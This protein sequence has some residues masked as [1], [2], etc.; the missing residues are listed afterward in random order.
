MTR[1]M[2]ILPMVFL[3][4]VLGVFLSAEVGW[5]GE[6]QAVAAEKTAAL[7]SNEEIPEAI[8]ALQNTGKAFV[9]IGKSVKPAVVAIETK[10]Q[11]EQPK[12]Q[13]RL[14]TPFDDFFGGDLRRHFSPFPEGPRKGLG[15]GVIVRKEGYI[16]TNNHVIQG[17]DKISVSLSDGRKFE[18]EVIGK[19]K[20]T[21]LA[22]IK[23]DGEDLSV[24]RFGDSDALEVGEWVLAF[25]NP[26]EQYNTMTQGIVSAKGREHLNFGSTTPTYQNFIQ[27]TAFIN[28][29]NSGGA[30]VNLKGELVGINA[31]IQST[32]GG[33]MG[34]G[35]AIPV[36]MAQSVMED[37]IGKGR[38]VRG[39]LGVNISEVD[40]D[41]ADALKLDEPHGA[42]VQE[43]MEDEGAQQAGMQAGDVILEVNGERIEN[44]SHLQRTIAQQDPGKR[45]ELT[46]WRDGSKKK[47]RVQ[48]GERPDAEQ[49]AVHKEEEDS[50]LGV[51]VQ[52]LT[53][54]MGSQL[55]YQDEKGVVVSWVDPNGPAAE[56]GIRRGDLIQQIGRRK[57]ASTKEYDKAMKELIA[58]QAVMILVK[59]QESVFFVAI[60][61]PKE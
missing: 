44:T 31:A 29:G 25:G 32:N 2:K 9:A 53:E 52:A 39:Y 49:M 5:L 41:M 48:L 7:G 4:L 46:V 33:F 18:A 35:F 38:V 17:A 23:I 36:N 3:L 22:V 6:G 45:V 59:R 15:S 34:I 20:L 21:D 60:K 13:E 57:I 10:T 50:K 47:L 56:K 58:G 16:L 11:V 8:H 28:P 26:F 37:L 1:S 55:G 43:V 54:D 19:D 61:I 12:A 42:M 30:L 27:T 14:R 40:A 51:Q 24:I